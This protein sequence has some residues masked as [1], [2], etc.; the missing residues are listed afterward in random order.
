MRRYTTWYGFAASFALAASIGMQAAPLS[1]SVSTGVLPLVRSEGLT[2]PLGD[3]MVVCTGGTPTLANVQVPA[4]TL[5]V[6]LN[7][8]ATSHV[9]AASEFS[10]ALL[11]VD[12]PNTVVYGKQHPLLNC[13]DIGAPD[14]GPSGA[15][16]CA[17]ISDGVP[18]DTYDGTRFAQG[19]ST[20]EPPAATVVPAKYMCGRPNAFQG[21]LGTPF[22]PGAMNAITF[23][24]VPFDPPGGG[25]RILRITNLRGNASIIPGDPIYAYVSIIGP[26]SVPIA[27]PPVAEL[28]FNLPGLVP[29]ISAAGTIRVTEGFGSAF[30]D[31]NVAF[32]IGNPAPGN[33]TYIPP[34]TYNGGLLYPPQMAQNVPGSIYSTEDMFQWQPPSNVPSPNPPPGFGSGPVLNLGHPLDSFGYLINTGISADGVAT[35]GTRIALH[36]SGVP[37]GESVVCRTAVPLRRA[38]TTSPITGVLAMTASDANGA[39][40][41]SP[42]FPSLLGSSAANLVVYEV[43]YADPFA[44]EYGD[45]PCYLVTPTGALA[46]PAAVS[47]T[48]SFAPFYG[49]VAASRPTPTTLDPSPVA[50]PRFAPGSTSYKVTLGPPQN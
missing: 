28:A 32:T 3:V 47:V 45:I 42:F 41:Y 43:L 17:T 27:P 12:E 40:A 15:G 31:R 4:V 11:L 1:C 23:E 33:A 14:N 44:I 29:S 24:G 48:P 26:L 49:G 6:V 10:E 36:F 46:S 37:A 34:W 38:A 16:V 19:T 9:T 7:V 5:T 30:K 39:G 13:G 35:Q 22:L 18:T 21:R 2:E 50:I 25:V 20:C 8:N